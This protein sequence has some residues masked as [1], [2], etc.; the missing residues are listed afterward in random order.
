MQKIKIVLSYDGSGFL[1]WASQPGKRTVEGE[2]KNGLK[3]VLPETQDFFVGGRTDA[4]VHAENQVVS[5]SSNISENFHESGVQKALNSAIPTDIFVKSV[6]FINSD[7]NARFSAVSRTYIFYLKHISGYSVFQRNYTSYFGKE[8]D[9][10]K[11]RKAADDCLGEYNFIGFS[12]SSSD[13]KSFIREVLKIELNGDSKSFTFEIKANG[14]L[15]HMIRLIM[16]T[17]IEIG[18]GKLPESQVKNILHLEKRGLTGKTASPNGLFLQR[19][20]YET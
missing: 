9:F 20:N 5:F 14:F 13:S 8:L 1:G 10:K 11:I 15:T 3:K 2:F 16:G 6:E 7:F 4:G 19:I 12:S 17:L 18:A